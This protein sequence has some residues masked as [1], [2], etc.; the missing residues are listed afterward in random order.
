[1]DLIVL[2][3]KKTSLKTAFTKEKNIVLQ[4]SRVETELSKDILNKLSNITDEL[5]DVLSN[6]LDIIKEDNDLLACNKVVKELEKVESDFSD[7]STIVN[8]AL[9][10]PPQP[11]QPQNQSQ[12]SNVNSLSHHLKPISVPTFSGDKENFEQWKADFNVIFDKAPISNV[13]KL[14]QMKQ[15]LSGE[16]ARTIEH[17][18]FSEEAYDTARA[19][20]EEKY[21]GNRRQIALTL[22]ALNSFRDVRVNEYKDL[23]KFNDLL[24]MS[25]QALKAAK[26]DTEL[27]KGSLY[28]TLTKK[29]PQEYYMQYLRWTV[30]QS[31]D[32]SVELLLKWVSKEAKIHVAAAEIAFGVC[33]D[34]KRNFNRNNSCSFNVKFEVN[35][36]FCKQ[37][38]KLVNCHKFSCLSCKDRWSFAWK[39]CLCFCC[40]EVGHSGRDCDKKR[41]CE[42]DNCDNTH[43]PLLHTDTTKSNHQTTHNSYSIKSCGGDSLDQ[44]IALRTV[45]VML[46]NGSKQIKVMHF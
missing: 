25:V 27:E 12:S 14:L 35:C 8:K 44:V 38:H 36:L 28:L 30:D 37:N 11:Q 24:D 45:P 22:E 6:L 39:E 7:I 19:R 4:C 17:V 29:L 15:Y 34:D 41:T 3:A 16:A 46:R 10:E 23:E 1:M 40:L 18:G 32:E 21:G 2:K 43:H 31:E 33:G 9:G 42:I 26:M 13:H 20:L 5:I